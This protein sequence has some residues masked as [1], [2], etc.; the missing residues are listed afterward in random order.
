MLKIDK[1]LNGIKCKRGEPYTSNEF[2]RFTL[3]YVVRKLSH[4]L[5]LVGEFGINS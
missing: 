2:I 4:Y 5:E 1:N 3:V